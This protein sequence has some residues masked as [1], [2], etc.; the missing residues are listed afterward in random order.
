MARVTV[1]HAEKLD[2]P[3]HPIEVADLTRVVDTR[4]A[5]RRSTA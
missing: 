1:G 3:A 2:D 4:P 5:R